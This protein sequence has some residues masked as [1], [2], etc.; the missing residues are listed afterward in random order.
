MIPFLGII[1]GLL[2]P[3]MLVPPYLLW[4]VGILMMFSSNSGVM[5]IVAD[6][7]NLQAEDGSYGYE[8]MSF[9]GISSPV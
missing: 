5:R 7:G 1:N 9:V 2:T 8:V 3:I 6:R 4:M